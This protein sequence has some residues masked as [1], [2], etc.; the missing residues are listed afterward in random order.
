MVGC[1]INVNYVKLLTICL[2]VPSY[3]EREALKYQVAIVSLFS[4]PSG[5][6]SYILQL[7]YHVDKYLL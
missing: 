2:L 7:C 4:V 6:A 1:P 3:I 5:F